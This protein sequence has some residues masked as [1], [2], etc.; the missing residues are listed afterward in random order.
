ME[1]TYENQKKMYLTY[2]HHIEIPVEFTHENQ[3]KMISKKGKLHMKIRRKKIYLGS[4]LIPLL[5]QRF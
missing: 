3:K 1:I 5:F 4:K 2:E